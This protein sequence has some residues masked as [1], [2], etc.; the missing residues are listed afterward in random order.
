M[1]SRPVLLRRGRLIDGTSADATDLV[2]ILIEG[3]TIRE[4]SPEPLTSARAH[5][6]ELAGRA[7][8]PGL[9][10]AH[11]HA[12]VVDNDLGAL[13]DCPASYTALKAANG[14]KAMLHRGFTTARDAAGADWG[15]KQ[16]LADGVIDGP[17]LFI[18]GHAISPTGGHGDYRHRND[19]SAPQCHCSTALATIARVA[20]GAD[21]I[22]HAVRDEL[23][24]GADHIKVMASGGLSG[25]NSRLDGREFADEE[26]RAAVETAELRGTYVMAHA[27]GAAAIRQ[28]ILAGVRSIEHAN[29]IDHDAAALAAG[30]G[31]FVVPTLSAYWQP[32]TASVA[33]AYARMLAAGL[34]SVETCR[35]AGVQMGFGSDLFGSLQIEQAREFVLRRE[36]QPAHEI[37]ASATRINAR[38]IGMEGRLGIIAPQAQADILVVSGDPLADIAVLGRPDKVH[39]LMQGGVLHKQP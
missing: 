36:V 4:V 32:E 8:L 16:A 19:N 39:L 6:I 28:A 34:M 10:D 3:D 11:V 18:A 33:T 14:L 20:D 12:N 15:L 37:I 23:R 5:V 22:R 13:R 26:L 7:V 17:R 27:Y 25:R 38:I 24:K 31:A 35:N 30:R 21:A 9:I 1:T 29:L 2:D